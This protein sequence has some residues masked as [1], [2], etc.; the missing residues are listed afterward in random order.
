MEKVEKAGQSQ[1]YWLLF[2][3]H[4]QLKQDG[5]KPSDPSLF[6]Q[7]ISALSSSFATQ[8]TICAG[9]TNFFEAK[10]RESFLAHVSDPISE[11]WKRELL[12]T[13]SSDT[14]LFNQPLLE[15]VSNQLKEDSLL[16]SSA[17]LSKMSKF[18]HQKSA[19]SSFKRYSSPLDYSRPGTSGY[20]K[21]SRSPIRGRSAKRARGGR[22]RSPL[23]S[24]QRGF[25]K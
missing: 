23:A 2:A 14:F 13:A 5:F 20:C 18:G 16:S 8:T 19:H 24:S 9:L 21:R 3:L 11:P 12:T 4:S 7:N 22:G 6:D 25:R 10:H 1:C 15:K 17:S